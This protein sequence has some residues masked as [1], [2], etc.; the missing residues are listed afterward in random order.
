LGRTHSTSGLA[1]VALVFAVTLSESGVG[2]AG[3]A[4]PRRSGPPPRTEP[5]QPIAAVAVETCA[6]TGTTKLGTDVV[7]YD[8]VEGGRPIAQFAGAVTPLRLGPF[9]GAGTERVPVATGT[10]SGSFRIQGY[11]DSAQVPLITTRDIPVVADHVWI[12]AQQEVVFLG[13]GPGKLYVRKDLTHPL[14][15]SFKGWATCDHFSLTRST[16]TEWTVPGEARGY[17]V[18]Q[19]PTELFSLPD[20]KEPPVTSLIGARGMLLWSEEQRGAFV[21]LVYHGEVVI[22]AWGRLRDFRALPPGETS[23]RLSHAVV[24]PNP[25]ALKLADSPRVVR[26]KREVTLRSGAHANAP[27]IGKIE[28][29]TDTYVLDIVAGFASVLPKSLHVAPHGDGQ[30]WAKGTDL[31]L[32]PPKVR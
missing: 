14:S 23:D 10:G 11:L 12:A 9:P 28:V 22:N 7:I 24:A 13:A 16:R 3:P 29:G 21:H 31:G 25:P 4:S 8:R 19:D 6:L 18:Q 30:F 2:A 17:L 27:V 20:T 32:P 26:T 15:Q 1:L 5:R